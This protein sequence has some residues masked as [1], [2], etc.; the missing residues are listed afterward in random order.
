M[1]CRYIARWEEQG[2]GI[3]WDNYYKSPLPDDDYSLGICVNMMLMDAF[4]YLLI[5][6]YLEN[7]M[8]GNLFIGNT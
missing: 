1:A 7:I 4:I 2:I 6:W 5:M 3:Q 8:P